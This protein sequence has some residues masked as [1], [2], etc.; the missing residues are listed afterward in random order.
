MQVKNKIIERLDESAKEF[1][2]RLLDDDI[3]IC[4]ASERI[5]DRKNIEKC[6]DGYLVYAPTN[7]Q[8][9]FCQERVMP[10]YCIFPDMKD[11]AE[12]WSHR[13]EKEFIRTYKTIDAQ[14]DLKEAYEFLMRGNKERTLWNVIDYNTLKKFID[15]ERDRKI[16]IVE[17]F[18]KGEWSNYICSISGI[19][20]RYN[21]GVSYDEKDLKAAMRHFPKYLKGVNKAVFDRFAKS[22]AEM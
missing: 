2:Y 3:L 18:H 13:T 12:F 4:K 11:D 22:E 10:F 21:C 7:A 17:V 8:Q 20:E 16:E 1:F 5:P 19:K 9:P 6:G 14:Y 15:V